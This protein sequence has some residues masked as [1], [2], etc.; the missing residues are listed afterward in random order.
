M[1]E[2]LKI[3][4]AHP[5][6]GNSLN[7]IFSYYSD[8]VRDLGAIFKIFCPMIGK[9]YVRN[10]LKHKAEGYKNPA[11]T[12]HAIKERDKWMVQNSDIVVIDFTDSKIVSIGCCMELAWA[13]MLGKHTIVI[14]EEDNIHRHAFVLD[15]ADI[16]FNT[17]EEA[18]KYLLEL[19]RG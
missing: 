16:V 19:S 2:K 1:S 18:V 17:Q 8:A 14:L 7:E 11:S 10:E 6:S 5:I 12:N 4:L 3:Y 9:D 13:D 15:C